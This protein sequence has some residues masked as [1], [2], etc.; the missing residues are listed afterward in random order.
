MTANK[1]ALT[2]IRRL[3]DIIQDPAVETKR[4]LSLPPEYGKLR[5]ELRDFL[6][7]SESKQISRFGPLE[8]AGWDVFWCGKD[9]AIKTEKGLI[10]V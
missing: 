8:R 1:T 2:L 3:H 10:V 9:V 4:V 6:V 5:R 7:I